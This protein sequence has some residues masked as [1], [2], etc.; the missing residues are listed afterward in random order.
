MRTQTAK[1]KDARAN[2]RATTKCR[3]ERASVSFRDM[4]PRPALPRATCSSVSCKKGCPCNSSFWGDFPVPSFSR[5]RQFGLS[6]RRSRRAPYKNIYLFRA[7]TCVARVTTTVKPERQEG[8][9]TIPA[10]GLR[11]AEQE[12]NMIA[13]QTRYR[14]K[15]RW[16]TRTAVGLRRR[17]DSRHDK[18][19]PHRRHVEDQ[20]G[21]KPT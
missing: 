4:P 10:S 1:H 19:I 13:R 11:H 15:E 8:T 16:D 21:K 7:A 6:C 2:D 12:T 20:H 17:A 18:K 5:V 14:A 3:S 9:I